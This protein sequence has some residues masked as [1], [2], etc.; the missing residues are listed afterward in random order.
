MHNNKAFSTAHF[1]CNNILLNRFFLSRCSYDAH[2]SDTHKLAKL[3][4]VYYSP[5]CLFITLKIIKC[6]LLFHVAD[7]K[8]SGWELGSCPFLT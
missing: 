6:V 8:T 7:T 4:H 5:I 1:N 3:V 2:Q